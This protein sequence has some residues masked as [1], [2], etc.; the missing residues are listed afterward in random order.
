MKGADDIPWSALAASGMSRTGGLW[1][2]R[3]DMEKMRSRM[4]VELLS[5]SAPPLPVLPLS[6]TCRCDASAPS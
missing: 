3:D 2:G 5:G 1:D 6:G 4:R